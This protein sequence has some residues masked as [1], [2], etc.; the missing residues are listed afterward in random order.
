MFSLFP[1]RDEWVLTQE[2]PGVNYG[3]GGLS[4]GK[5]NNP[6]IKTGS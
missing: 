3:G 6:F 5:K 1:G 4:V 2:L